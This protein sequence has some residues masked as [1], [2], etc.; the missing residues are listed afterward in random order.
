LAEGVWVRRFAI[1]I[2]VCALSGIYA[3]ADELYVPS[4]DWPTIQSAIEGAETGDRVIVSGGIYLEN[5]NFLGKAITVRSVNPDDPDTVAETILDGSAPVDINHGSVVTFNSGEGNG[6]ILEGFTITGGTGTWLTISWRFHEIY[7]NRCGGGIVCYNL[8]APTIRK[9][10]I[11]NNRAGEGGGIYV[12]GDPVTPYPPVNP[13]VHI[14]PVIEGNLFENNTAQKTHEFTPPDTVY[15]FSEH[16]DG[17]AIVCFQGVD[18]VISG[19]TIQN[20]TA[21]YY[22]GGIHLRQWSN[23]TIENNTIQ[24]NRSLLGAGIHITYSSS[25]IVKGN[26]ISQN[27][28]SNLGGGG[29]YIYSEG[30]NPI[31]TLNKITNNDSSNGAG[32]ASFNLSA[33]RITNNL[34]AENIGYGIHCRGSSSPQIISNT[35]VNNIRA[36]SG[37][38]IYCTYDA[39]P[40]IVNNLIIQNGQS[41]GLS[42][43]YDSLPIVKYNNVWGNNIS[44]YGRDLTDQTGINGNIS[45]DPNFA[46]TELFHLRPTSPCRDTGD[47]GTTNAGTMD[48]DGEPRI[49]DGRIDIGADEVYFSPADLNLSGRVDL[50]DLAILIETW[51][52]PD[53]LND[54]LLLSDNWLWRGKWTTD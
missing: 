44:N 46:D 34:I 15:T 53:D 51:L 31:I 12:Y 3:G 42:A 37:G 54:F 38:G 39:N 27:K 22:G 35:I 26:H 1:A 33:A 13:A 32:I 10:R 9:N 29:I 11:V 49:A 50:E 47:P 20:N 7:W 28:A 43:A 2:L 23:G 52:S 16:G 21:D 24:N 48:I 14:K 4:S 36:I 8:S 19:N 41:Y 40:L 5:L 25:P 18:P 6:S 17:G 30:S 45:I